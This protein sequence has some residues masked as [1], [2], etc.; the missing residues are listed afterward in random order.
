MR[1][2]LNAEYIVVLTDIYSVMMMMMCMICSEIKQQT[3]IH[4]LIRLMF[5]QPFQ[6]LCK[7][8]FPIC[9]SSVSS[10]VRYEK[11]C[12]NERRRCCCYC[13]SSLKLRSS[14]VSQVTSAAT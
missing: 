1:E 13:R 8:T 3:Y 14:R 12:E 11:Q 7:I 5:E 6:L 2:M 4:I 10:Y 9:Y